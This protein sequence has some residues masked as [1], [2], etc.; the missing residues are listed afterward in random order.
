MLQVQNLSP[1]FATRFL[2]TRGHLP[3]SPSNHAPTLKPRH[4]ESGILAG[5]GSSDHQDPTRTA[6]FVVEEPNLRDFQGFRTVA[7]LSL[8]LSLKHTHTCVNF[9]TYNPDTPIR[10]DRN[11]TLITLL[12]TRSGQCFAHPASPVLCTRPLVRNT[13]NHKA[14]QLE[15]P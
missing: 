2:T 5:P 11:K 1:T 10:N 7:G 13:P 6:W 3:L 12:L 14:S 9:M 8:P 4:V 15:S